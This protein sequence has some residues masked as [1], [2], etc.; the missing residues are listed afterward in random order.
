MIVAAVIIDADRQLRSIGKYLSDMADHYIRPEDRLEFVFHATE[1]YSGGKIL[2]REKY[3]KEVRW[4]ILDELATIPRQFDLPVAF[5]SVPRAWYEP[6]GEWHEKS[7]KV[8]IKGVVAAQMLAFT[9]ASVG[10]EHWMKKAADADEIAQMVM[11]NN[12]EAQKFIRLTHKI[13]SDPKYQ[14]FLIKEDTDRLSTSRTIETIHF[15]EK[16]DSS[17][18][19][20]ADYCA[21]AIRRRLSEEPNCGRFCNPLL[22][23]IVAKL[24]GMEAT[25]VDVAAKGLPV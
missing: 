7:K 4:C 2:T 12:P 19:Q 11:E 5:G 16:S 22:P 8:D 14:A 10:I 18:L 25:W 21:W 1:L 9:I 3:P 24:K 6:G 13:L 20:V 23:Q 17:A 15:E